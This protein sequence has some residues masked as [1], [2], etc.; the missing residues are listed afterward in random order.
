MIVYGW[1]YACA[2]NTM[3]NFTSVKGALRLMTHC[4]TV[5]VQQKMIVRKVVEAN[6]ATLFLI[7]FA[8]A[9]AG[10]LRNIFQGEQR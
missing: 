7:R 1:M 2:K 5:I 9:D 8:M 3:K 6:K 10:L 4:E